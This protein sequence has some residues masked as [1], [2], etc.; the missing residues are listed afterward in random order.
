[1]LKKTYSIIAA[2]ALSSL[3]FQAC[4]TE[5]DIN[6][7]Y[8]ETTIVFGTIGQEFLADSSGTE[9]ILDTHWVKINKSF[10]GDGSAF[11]YAQIRD[12]SEYAEEDLVAEV[13]RWK[14]GNQLGTYELR[15][16]VVNHREEG[17]FYYPEQ[18]VYYFVENNID[19]ESEYVVVG[20]AKGKD[21]SATANVI[22]N[23]NVDRPQVVAGDITLASGIGNYTEYGVEWRSAENGKRYEVSMIIRWNDVT[24]SG[25]TPRELTRGIVT[26]KSA[27]TNGGEDLEG[28]IGGEDFYRFL[29]NNI[30]QDQDIIRREFLGLDF[31]FETANEELNTYM[32]L[33]EP[34]TGIVQDRPSFTNVE[35][36]LGIFA[37]R[38]KKVIL[39]KQLS[40]NSIKELVDGQYTGLLRFCTLRDGVDPPYGCF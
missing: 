35:N 1:M 25:S 23:L 20:T 37:A 31:V 15:D 13:Q 10:Q 28:V 2:A 18:K 8:N 6:A 14:N 11:D 34:V 9:Q 33:N 22:G 24:N 7:P 26:R 36:G 27:G 17:I 38:Q 4:E 3:L 21:F 5:L 19:T 40:G 32:E 16:T 12:S 39:K 29:A 30:P